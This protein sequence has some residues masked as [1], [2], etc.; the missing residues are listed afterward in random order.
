MRPALDRAPEEKVN[1]ISS[2][3]FIL[4]HLLPFVAIFTGVSWADVVLLIALYY[5]RLFFI[6][7]GYHR[8]FSHRSYKTNRVMQAILAFGGTM[9][10]QKGPLWWAAHHRDHHR[11]SD[12]ERDIHSPLKG[13]WWSHVGW[14][15]CDRYNET[16]LENI[17]DFA[18]YPEIRFIDKHNWMGPWTLGVLTFVFFGWSGLFFS[19]FGSQVLAWHGT[20]LVNSLAHVFGRRRYVTLD[21]SRNSMLIAVLTLGEGWHNNHHY[22]QASVRQGFFW[23]EFDPSFYIIKT[24]SF[25]GLAK[26]LKVP[27]PRVLAGERIKE[28]HFDMGMFGAYY[29]KAH[30]ALESAQTRAGDYAGAKK[31]ALED[32]VT[33]TRATA[34]TLSHMSAPKPNPA[35]ATD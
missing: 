9:A 30:K 13:F 1:W 29:A 14:I 34:E 24:M 26:D 5:L 25:V 2:I 19:F 4:V 17:Q 12:T 22:Y 7:A 27:P 33:S 23:W 21:T 3:P 16:K 20:F 8:Y 10:A 32:F 6:T 11:Y 15:L 35:Q 31:R 28:G 18:K